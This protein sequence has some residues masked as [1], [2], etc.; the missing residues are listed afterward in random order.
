MRVS[1]DFSVQILQP[2]KFKLV[3]M[4]DRRIVIGKYGAA[5]GKGLV[6]LPGRQEK[7]SLGY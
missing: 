4:T 3:H 1:F 6:E 2:M 5:H 7:V